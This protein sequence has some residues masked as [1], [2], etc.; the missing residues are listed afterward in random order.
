LVEL[1]VGSV[2]GLP[3]VPVDEFSV[4]LLVKLEVGSNGGLDAG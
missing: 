2:L 1:V 4:G 3:D